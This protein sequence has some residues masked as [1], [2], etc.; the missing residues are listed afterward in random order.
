MHARRHMPPK[1]FSLI[2]LLIVIAIV[3]TLLALLLPAVTAARESARR[4][5]CIGNLR[6]IGLAVLSYETVHNEFPAGRV[7][8]D[9]TGDEMRIDVCP[10]EL[11]AEEKTAASGFVRLLPQLEEQTLFDQLSIET[12]GLWNRNVDDLSWYADPEKCKG[13]KQRP[14]CLV[15]PSDASA[16]I[17]DVYFPVL[18]ATSSY[19]L[20]Q[21]KLGPDSP[22]HQVKFFNDGMFLYVKA[23]RQRQIRDGLSSTAMLGEVRFSDTWESS[24]TWTYALANAD[25]LRNTR[26]P[27]N[28]VPGTGVM[29]ERQ[30]GA[31]GSYHPGGTVFC[32]GD[33]RAAF[34]STEIDNAIYQGLATIYGGEMSAVA[35]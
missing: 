2:E 12:G 6:Q 19:A 33:D 10:P 20:M 15:C 24:N 28:T 18:A 35:W 11:P 17:S 13:I 5:A 30:N 25:C 3:G 29:L 21:G 27:L 22:S 1:A 34:L 4:T 23:R 8:C 16:P 26:N 14:S 32:F 9:D 31:F 7:G